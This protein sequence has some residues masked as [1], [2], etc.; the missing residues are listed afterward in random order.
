MGFKTGKLSKASLLSFL[1]HILV[2]K[3][4]IKSNSINDVLTIPMDELHEWYEIDEH[5]ISDHMPI[6]PISVYY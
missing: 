4:F 3:N 2:S 1:D 6:L 5:Y